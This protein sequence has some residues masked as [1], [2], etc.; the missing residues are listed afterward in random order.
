[1]RRNGFRDL[2]FQVLPGNEEIM[3]VTGHKVSSPDCHSQSTN[4]IQCEIWGFHGCDYEEWRLLV[5]YALWL[6]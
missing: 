2:R 1:M 6:L 5:C 3:R 4:S